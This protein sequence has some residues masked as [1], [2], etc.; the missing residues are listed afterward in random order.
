MIYFI[1]TNSNIS[2]TEAS[3]L[4]VIL[5]CMPYI[6]N[7]NV[8]YD[9]DNSII[10]TNKITTSALN[11]YEYEEIFKPFWEDEKIYVS[12][13]HKQSST[14]DNL[15][16]AQIPNLTV[17]DSQFVGRAQVEVLKRVMAS[18]PYDDIK[19]FFISANTAD[20]ARVNANGIVLFEMSHGIAK[21]IK[22]F[23]K[24][25]DAITELK[26]YINTELFYSKDLNNTLRY[27]LGESFIGGVYS[28]HG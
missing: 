25:N 10:A 28:R 8:Y 9:G 13:S 7:G 19:F 2:K 21:P 17:I 4:G 16:M 14:F 6:M 18:K 3:N 23:N 20:G 27:H 26:K 1:D 11:Q 22:Q 12:F 5:I 15:N 24:E